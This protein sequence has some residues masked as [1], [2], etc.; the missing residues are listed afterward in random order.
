MVV[1]VNF[2]NGI[3]VINIVSMDT[4]ERDAL[5]QAALSAKQL[6]PSS[7][8]MNAVLNLCMSATDDAYTLEY[9]HNFLNNFSNY[10]P[11]YPNLDTEK[12]VIQ[13]YDDND[14]LYNKRNTNDTEKLKKNATTGISN[15]QQLS[16]SETLTKLFK[17][18]DKAKA[19]YSEYR[20]LHNI[21]LDILSDSDISDTDIDEINKKIQ[22]CKS[23]KADVD[24]AYNSL[25]DFVRNI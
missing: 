14:K 7:N 16:I 13:K 21:L 24:H 9:P 6:L 3:A 23:K 20:V 19:A 15:K 2:E 18:Y 12:N 8:K 10:K 22:V 4:S 11:E 5:I 17:D 1:K 25:M